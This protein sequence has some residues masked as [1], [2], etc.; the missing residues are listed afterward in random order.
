MIT[1]EIYRG[2]GG[3]IQTKI[4]VSYEPA[5]SLTSRY[6]IEYRDG[7]GNWKQMEPTTLTSVDIP[8]VKD[9][10]LYQIRIK[11][12]NVLGVWSDNPI[13]NYEPIGRLR[14]PHNVS[15]LR[16][17]AIAQEGA[18]LIWDLS[19]DIDLE[20]YEIKKGDTYES[21]KPVGKIKANEFNLGFIR[22]GEHKYWLSAVD[23]SDVRSE[24][25][26]A[27]MFNISGGQVE[28]LVA[29]IVGDEVLMT[30]SE[31]K[32]TLFRLSSTRLKKM[33]T[34]WL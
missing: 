4:V 2:L 10:V 34:C 24:S 9:G 11:T 21:S 27:V 33:M 6:Q 31:T 30:W 14:P 19:P 15:N 32:T 3:S 28:N 25:P 8:N 5:T 29:E 1:D 7:N 12:S 17:K 18:F 20:Y 16:H 13:Q 22:A 23:S 26:T